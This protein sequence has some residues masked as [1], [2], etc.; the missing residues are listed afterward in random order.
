LIGGILK[1]QE[2]IANAQVTATIAQ[3]KGFDAAIT[4]FKDKYGQLPGDIRAPGTRLPSCASICGTAG[5]GNGR[6]DTTVTAAYNNAT[7][8]YRAFLHLAAANLIQGVTYNNNAPRFGENI[9]A[10]KAGG[11][12]RLGYDNDGNLAGT[13]LANFRPGHILGYVG[14]TT[15]AVGT[16][17]NG[18][19]AASQGAQID[20]KL[21]DGLPNSGSVEAIGTGCIVG[22][23][24]DER[25]NG[26]CHIFI[27]AQG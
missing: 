16:D 25:D 4:T 13:G 3:I 26:K 5:N 19:V 18:A 6:V 22:T 9:P 2:L 12:F 23:A 27:Q 1:G 17:N 14:Q 20:R 7:E 21:D 24:Y 15:A 8:G 10:G 11:G